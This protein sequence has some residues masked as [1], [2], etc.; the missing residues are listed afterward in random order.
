MK[1]KTTD[2]KNIPGYTFIAEADGISEYRLKTNGLTVLHKHIPDTAVVT[3]NITYAVG[4]RDEASG[5]TGIAHMLEHMLFKPTAQDLK[6]NIDSSAMQLERETGCIINANTW[7]DRTTYFFS[8]P[9][10]HFSRALQ[11]EAERMLDVVI[12]DKEF[13]PERGNVLSEFDMYNG[14]PHFALN[15]QMVCAAFHSH[16]YGHET[17]GFR[18]DIER[19]TPTKLQRFYTNYYRPD[20]ATLTIVGDISLNEALS[21]TKKQFGNLQNPETTIPRHDV[22]EP[23]QEGLRRVSITRPSSTNLLMIG[24]KHEGFPTQSWLETSALLSVLTG[25]P[26]SILHTK[27]VDAGLASSVQ[28]MLEPTSEKNLGM[29]II[30]LAP[31]SSHEEIETMTRSIIES[32]RA[33]DIKKLLKKVIQSEITE[34][35][36]ARG[37]SLHIAME[38]TEYISANTW[39]SYF[40]TVAMLKNI[41]P[42]DLITI[43]KKLFVESKMTIGYFIGTK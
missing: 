26:D 15:V 23:I 29:I 40:D 21:G 13:L 17:I 9:V 22:V 12:T 33:S 8:Y 37:S 34:E 36:F 14:D 7:K 19:Y 43:N 4:S 16:P 24:V 27:L 30:A 6:K 35:L 41:K 20:N 28:S 11:V 39:Q 2:T 38:L 3:S 1:K 5:E 42:T 25:G 32:L 31:G 18:E 10:E